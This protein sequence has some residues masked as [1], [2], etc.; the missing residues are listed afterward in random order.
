LDSRYRCGSLYK[1]RWKIKVLV[2]QIKSQLRIKT[3]VG[4]S[5]NAGM[6]QLWTTLITN[7]LLQA[8]QK[9][10]EY[11]LHLSNL[12]TFLRMHLFVKIGLKSY[13]DRPFEHESLTSED[14]QLSLLTLKKK[15]G[16]NLN[17]H[18]YPAN[19]L[20]VK[21]VYNQSKRYGQH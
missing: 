11:K 6:F 3:F 19:S 13:L 4:T 14:I 8:Y 5:E 16:G 1:E 12:I 7:L 2:K 17:Q 20:L 18:V 9:K 15:G 10:A 21:L